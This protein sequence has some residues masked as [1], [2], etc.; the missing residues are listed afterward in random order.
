MFANHLT[1]INIL[2]WV[3]EELTTVLQL[4]DGVGKGVAGLQSDHRTVDTALYLTLIGL[5]LLEAVG[6]DG[7]TLRGGQHIGAQTDDAARGNVELDIGALALALHRGHLTFTTG[8]HINHLRGK[9]LGHVD[10]QFLDR[11]ALLTVYLLV[12]NLGLAYLQLIA[13]ATHGLDEHGEMQHAT[14]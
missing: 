11:L 5:I 14:S 7:F 8:H 10:G 2:T 1:H 3:D 4:V 13:L 12:D 9:L 6:H